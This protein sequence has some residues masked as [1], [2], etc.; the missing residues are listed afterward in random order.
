MTLKLFNWILSLVVG[1]ISFIINLFV[2]LIPN[3]SMPNLTTATEYLNDFWE[4][5]FS[6]FSWICNALSLTPLSINLII[7][8]FTIKYLAKPTIT[9]VKM[10]INW[11]WGSKEK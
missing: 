7:D 8:I 10:A 4:Y 6:A 3:A 9:L 2:G 11:V 1:T 5:V